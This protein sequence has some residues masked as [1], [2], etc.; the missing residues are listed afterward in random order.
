MDDL[1][2]EAH[3][4]PVVESTKNALRGKSRLAIA[5]KLFYDSIQRSLDAKS[6]SKRAV[7]SF[8]HKHAFEVHEAVT[9]SMHQRLKS[10]LS[11]R[12]V[13]GEEE[14]LRPLDEL[15]H[16]LKSFDHKSSS[17]FKDKR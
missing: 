6:K 16:D 17:F 5:Q 3:F 14:F 2:L 12:F 13:N 15:Q 4:H 7:A 11:T 9:K 8:E 10:K 1:A